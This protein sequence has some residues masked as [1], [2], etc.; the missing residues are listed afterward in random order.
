MTWEE[1]IAQRVPLNPSLRH[2]G[3]LLECIE[4]VKRKFSEA[5]VI[6]DGSSYKIVTPLGDV[7]NSHSCHY[8]CWL[9][10]RQLVELS[11]A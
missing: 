3:H 10:A 11:N 5:D 1:L 6:A 2:S 9:E 7:T 4:I 8:D